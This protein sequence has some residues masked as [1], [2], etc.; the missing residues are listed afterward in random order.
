MS[1]HMTRPSVQSLLTHKPAILAVFGAPEPSGANPMPWKNGG[2]LRCRYPG[3]SHEKF[4]SGNRQ[5]FRSN[6]ALELDPLATVQALSWW[7]SSALLGRSM[8]GPEPCS[9]GSCCPGTE[10]K[11]LWWWWW[12]WEGGMLLLFYIAVTHN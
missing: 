7:I 10:I 5:V 3:R 11:T 1:V 12:W 2:R 8:P 4:H 9:I 6:K